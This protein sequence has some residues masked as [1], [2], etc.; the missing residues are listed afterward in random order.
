L[1]HLAFSAAKPFHVG[2]DLDGPACLL[3]RPT[4]CGWQTWVQC[5]L[6][7]PARSHHVIVVGGAFLRGARPTRKD[8]TMVLTIRVP[9]RPNLTWR[10]SLLPRRVYPASELS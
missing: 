1:L 10:S 3:H 7:G 2:A 4:V 9:E 8:I 6:T 5:S